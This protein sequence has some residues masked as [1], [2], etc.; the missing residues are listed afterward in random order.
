MKKVELLAACRNEKCI[1][2][3]GQK[4][5]MDPYDPGQIL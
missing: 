3:C 2:N 5:L 1:K 4:I